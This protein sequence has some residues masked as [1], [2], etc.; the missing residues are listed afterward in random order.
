MNWEDARLFLAVARAGQMLGAAKDARGQSG[1]TQPPPDSARNGARHQAF[2]S[3]HDR[4][5]ADRTGTGAFRG[6]RAGRRTDPDRRRR[7]HRDQA[8]HDGH[9]PDRRAG[10][11][12]RFVSRA[13][14]RQ[15]SRSGIPDLKLELVPVSRA[16]SLSH[17]EADMAILV[18]RPQKGR[19]VGKKLTDYSLGPL[20]LAGYLD[21][22]GRPAVGCRSRDPSAGRLCRRPHSH[23]RIELCPEVSKN[24]R[25]A[26]SISSAMGQYAGGASGAGIG[27]LHDY[28]AAGDPGAGAGPAR[29]KDYP[30]LLD[31]RA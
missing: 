6:A 25:N 29:S 30:R 2:V 10:R 3:Q 9:G 5:S 19:L 12:R 17:R 23:A 24:W 4:L 8:S 21:R 15:A 20:R 22:A 28:I 14:A 26:V 16:F 11:V 18:G 27:I 7:D 1:N 13:A 31:R